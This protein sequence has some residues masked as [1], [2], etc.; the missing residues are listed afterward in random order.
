MSAA[1]TWDIRLPWTAPPLSANDR[2]HYMAEARIK[3]NIR[4]TTHSLARSLRPRITKP[5]DRVEVVLTYTPRD[6]RRRDRMNLAPTLKAAVD[7]LV[8]AGVV[9]DDDDEH[10]H[11]D[12][13]I[14]PP[15]GDPRLVLHIRELP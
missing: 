14:A 8:L 11:D 6:K 1:R 10:M 5:L 4:D 13:R 7:G 15:D 3:A 2:L 9:V 12:I